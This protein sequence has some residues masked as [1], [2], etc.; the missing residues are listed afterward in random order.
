MALTIGSITD[1]S[2]GDATGSGL[3]FSI[4]EGFLAS[5][6]LEDMLNELGAGTRKQG[7]VQGLADMATAIATGVVNE[8]TS[9]GE[10]TTR[11][12]TSDAIQRIP[13][14]VVAGAPT[15]PPASTQTLTI[16]GSI[17]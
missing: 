6:A 10:V 11:V 2:S 1:D 7:I 17:A 8:F 14:P 9:N 4:L 5:P 12:S 16:K 13:N 15:D 3:S